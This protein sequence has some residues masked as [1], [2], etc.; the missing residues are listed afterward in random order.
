MQFALF[1]QKANRLRLL[2]CISELVIR[3]VRLTHFNL[4]SEEA[5]YAL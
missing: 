1:E 4:F 2:S 5:A 3:N